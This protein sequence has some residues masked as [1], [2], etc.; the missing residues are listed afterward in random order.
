MAPP[1]PPT[2]SAKMVYDIHWQSQN[3]AIA[4]YCQEQPWKRSNERIRS[5][6]S[7]K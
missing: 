4:A 3:D 2:S 1:L 7:S 5:E 6:K